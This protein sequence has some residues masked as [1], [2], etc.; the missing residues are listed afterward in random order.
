M[1]HHLLCRSASPHAQPQDRKLAAV[2]TCATCDT[3]AVK[4]FSKQAYD[5][6]VVIVTCPG[7]Q[8]RHLLA[9]NLGWFGGQTNVEQVLAERGEEVKRMS[10]DGAI[11]LETLVGGTLAVRIA[12]ARAWLTNCGVLSQLLCTGDTCG[13]KTCSRNASSRCRQCC[14]AL[15]RLGQLLECHSLSHD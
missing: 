10:L 14:H 4:Q 1:S 2:F 12:E 13:G 6:G 3:R 8:N 5:T 9:D 15:I 7:C 11:D